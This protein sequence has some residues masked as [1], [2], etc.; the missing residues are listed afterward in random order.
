MKQQTIFGASLAF[1]L[2]IA[3][4]CSG[5]QGRVD[6]IALQGKIANDSIQDFVLTYNEEGDMLR[7]RSIDLQRD[8]DGNFQ[9]PDSLI[10]EGGTHATILAD[11][12]GYWGVYLEPGK[13]VTV[14]ITGTPASGYAIAFSGA[15]A[16]VNDAYNTIVTTY[17]IMTYS[18]QDPENRM[19][20]DDALARLESDRKKVNDKIATIKDSDK[21]AYYSELASLLSNRME[22]F[23]YED[24]AYENDADP[25]E[26][27]KYAALI[28]GVDPNSEVALE[29]GMIYLWINN[30]GRKVGGEDGYAKSLA[31]L[32]SVAENVN[33]PRSRKALF[34]MMPHQF[35]AYTKPT[36]E[37]AA[38]FMKGYAELAKD[39]PEFIDTYTMQAQGVKVVEAGE[40]L[41][42]DPVIA[43]TD[44]KTCKLSELYGK[45]LYIDFWA[46]W[47]GPCRKQ[48]P[49]L[50]KLV[51]RM[52]D[53]NGIE[54]ISISCD[55]DVEAWK[56]L[57]AKDKP[58]WPQYIFAEGQGDA[59][60]AAMNITGIPRFMI[61]GKDGKLIAPDAM[62]P[63]E[64]KLE[65][66]LRS[67]VK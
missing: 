27:P 4:A 58:T 60:M 10:P 53:V 15:N 11:S 33:N 51:E 46:T 56:E 20:T 61:I 24:A 59:F 63:S 55:N 19:T 40:D 26:N 28:E 67:L 62:M 13:T 49:H 16:D 22:G 30:E 44:G 38:E 57:V 3:G 66:Q 29:S 32:K 64:P 1:V 35:F 43:T 21:Q 6:G 18:P 2:L 54:F 8:A 41:R 9:I 39:Y 34:H 31:Q 23:I 48:I 52:K 17:D 12:E 45:V 50:E 65:D 47:C 36:P 37:D 25:W 5:N 7:Y 42:F 14:D